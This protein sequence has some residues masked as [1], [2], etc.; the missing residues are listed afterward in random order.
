MTGRRNSQF[1]PYGELIPAQV[2]NQTGNGLY[3]CIDKTCQYCES[4]VGDRDNIT[5]P[6]DFCI[7]KYAG[8]SCGHFL[9]LAKSTDD[10]SMECQGI[11]SVAKMFCCPGFLEPN[12]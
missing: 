6:S 10:G 2:N 8:L 7:P 5:V 4:A 9:E 12:E 3:R 1:G 11:Q